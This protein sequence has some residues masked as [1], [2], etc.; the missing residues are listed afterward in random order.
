MAKVLTARQA[1]RAFRRR[2]RQPVQDGLFWFPGWGSLTVSRRL[3]VEEAVRDCTGRQDPVV[4]I[5]R[6]LL[7]GFTPSALEM[8]PA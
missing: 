4:A 8:R 5:R 2:Y 3:A 6:L 7:P 1:W